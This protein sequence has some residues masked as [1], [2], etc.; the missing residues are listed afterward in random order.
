MF[1]S[2]PLSFS[3]LSFKQMIEE[4]LRTQC[5]SRKERYALRYWL[6]RQLDEHEQHLVYT[7]QRALH[8]GE[9]KIV[10]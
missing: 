3:P 7:L 6:L 10:D 9:I 4:I 2:E 8:T 1:M 5:M